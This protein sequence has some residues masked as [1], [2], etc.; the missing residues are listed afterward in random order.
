MYA[1]Q[2]FHGQTIRQEIP[3]CECGKV[4]NEKDIYDAPGV[5]FKKVDVFGKTYTLIE[6]ICPVC[7]KKIPAS[8]YILN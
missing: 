2:A 4:Y 8:Y 5:F 3:V 7:K 1:E 6:P